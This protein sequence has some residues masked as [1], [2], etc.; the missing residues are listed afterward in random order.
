M[1]GLGAMERAKICLGAHRFEDA[2]FH[3]QQ[4]AKAGD[5]NAMYALAVLS[6]LGAG[7]EQSKGLYCEWVRKAADGGS[8]V[9]LADCYDDGIG[10]KKSK[11][12]FFKYVKR[13]AKKGD[14]FAQGR[15]GLAYARPDCLKPKKA[16]FWIEKSSENGNPLAAILFHSMQE[17]A[18][19]SPESE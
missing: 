8:E 10:V 13:A 7:C 16:M 4:A 18:S 19:E 2:H 1:A 6:E 12:K 14:S 5:G 9:A 3:Y 11:R 17:K 15:L